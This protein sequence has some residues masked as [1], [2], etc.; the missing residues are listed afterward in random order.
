MGSAKTKDAKV[1]NIS[2]YLSISCLF[3]LR[4]W[5][6]LLLGICH[7]ISYLEV[8]VFREWSLGRWWEGGIQ[9]RR[10]FLGAEFDDGR[11]RTSSGWWA[12]YDYEFDDFSYGYSRIEWMWKIVSNLNHGLYLNFFLTGV[13][14]VR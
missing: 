1:E 4:F 14:A 7:A 9:I 10:A 6:V 2:Y 3:I 12:F 11:N 5:V 8:T 13:S